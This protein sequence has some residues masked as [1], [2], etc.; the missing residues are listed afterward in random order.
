MPELSGRELA[1]K[2]RAVRPEAK[3]LFISGYAGDAMALVG[4]LEP[5]MAYLQ[6]PFSVD[7]LA[8]KL[9]ELLDG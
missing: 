9:R 1:R 5:G 3:V 8:G 6:K 2:L 7:T 4:D